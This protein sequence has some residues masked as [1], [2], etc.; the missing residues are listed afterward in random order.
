MVLAVISRILQR[1]VSTDCLRNPSLGSTTKSA[2][3][4]RAGSTKPIRS[5][6]QD[7]FKNS[8]N[9]FP[10]MRM[11]IIF[12]RS[13]GDLARPPILE[14]VGPTPQ[15][16]VSSIDPTVPFM[17]Y[18]AAR[19][20]GCTIDPSD[21]LPIDRG[22][23]PAATPAPLPEDDPPGVYILSAFHSSR[24]IREGVHYGQERL[25]LGALH[26]AHRVIRSVLQEQTSLQSCELP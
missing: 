2:G 12:A 26:R 24:K 4:Q 9:D 19:V 25:R 23:K 14:K 13:S 20:A 6:F 18:N 21:S 5:P 17:P 8:E 10:P 22:A 11:L 3:C 1:Q 15:T 16:P 7:G